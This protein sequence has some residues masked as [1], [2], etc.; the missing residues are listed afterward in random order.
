MNVC[1]LC[2]EP[3]PEG[4]E[5]FFYHGYS[6][7]CPKPPLE[8]PKVDTV[9]EYVYRQQD[10]E[11]WLDI[12]ADRMPWAQIGPFSTEAERHAAKADMLNMMRSMGAKDLPTQPQ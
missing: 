3:M 1:K 9:V 7:P 8:K 10:G 5:M 4:E 2:G 12:V 6:G 11:F